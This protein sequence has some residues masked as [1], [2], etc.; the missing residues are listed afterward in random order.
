MRI[1]RPIQTIVMAAVALAVAGCATAS[2]PSAE[3]PSGTV[4]IITP[5]AAG[6][7]SDT[8]ARVAAECLKKELDGTFI[9]ENEAGGG[10]VVGMTEVAQ[11]K[12]NGQT[13]AVT[14]VSTAALVPLVTKGAEYGGS[15]FDPVY[16]I[17]KAPS[18]LVVKDDAPYAKAEDLIAAAKESPG[19]ISVAMPGSLGIFALTMDALAEKGAKFT[20]VPFESNDQ[21]A[22]AVIGGNAD[23]SYLSSSPTLLNQ[24]ESGELRVLATGNPERVKFL[25]DVP[26][27]S[28]LGYDDLPDSTVSVTLV[29]PKG[30][31]SSVAATL[32]ETMAT[33]ANKSSTA[34]T[35]G[36]EF[37]RT[38]EA[39]PELMRKEIDE[40]EAT[41]REAVDQ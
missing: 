2:K 12:P 32:E 29:G 13:L 5:F 39:G 6:G 1:H 33:C 34:K 35:L 14:S 17:T 9:V 31:K 21:S 16:G 30:L 40:A 41:W 18:V 4:K 27:F 11:A 24:I 7:I 23:S 8:T 15:D 26:T 20:N 3:Y 28:E 38:D 37:V 36:K 25:P 10:G 22:A 19:K